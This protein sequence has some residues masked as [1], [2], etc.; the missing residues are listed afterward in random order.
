MIKKFQDDQRLIDMSSINY[1]VSSFSS[2]KLCIK[3]E[4]YIS[5]DKLYPIG[6]EIGMHVKT[7]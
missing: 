2:L 4:F 5:N 6:V 3:C 1:L 7:I